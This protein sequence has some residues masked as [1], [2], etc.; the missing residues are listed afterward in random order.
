MRAWTEACEEDP[1]RTKRGAP[2]EVCLPTES[3]ECEF[4]DAIDADHVDEGQQ[5]DREPD[6]KSQLAQRGG[7]V[8]R[9]PVIDEV[10]R[11]SAEQDQTGESKTPST[12][13]FAGV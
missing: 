1:F 5:R 13:D 7:L 10:E 4:V 2:A 8:E 6:R 11:H 3:Q 9:R 12:K